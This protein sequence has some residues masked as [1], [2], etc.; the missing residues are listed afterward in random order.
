MSPFWLTHRV[1]S[2]LDQIPRIRVVIE[3][4]DLDVRTEAAI[5]DR[6]ND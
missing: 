4:S 2:G 5:N 6:M 3:T 1:R